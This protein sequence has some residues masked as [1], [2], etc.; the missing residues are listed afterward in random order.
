MTKP[1]KAKKSQKKPKQAKISQNKPRSFLASL[2]RM[3]TTFAD[4]QDD[5]RKSH[6][7]AVS[8]PKDPGWFLE[9]KQKQD[10]SLSLRMT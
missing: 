4:A 3:T 7:E 9:E 2:L 6:P 1:K 8:S 10:P 5:K